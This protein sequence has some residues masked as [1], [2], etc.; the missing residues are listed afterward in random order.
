[1]DTAYAFTVERMD[2]QWMV[3]TLILVLNL[4]SIA[5]RDAFFT[6]Q[7]GAKLQ[8]VPIAYPKSRSKIACGLQCTSLGDECTAYNFN[9]TNNLCELFKG[10]QGL[11]EATNHVFCRVLSKY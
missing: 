8:G 4:Q 5:G 9:L 11:M 7:K 1:M 10:Y 3:S 2:A 6:C